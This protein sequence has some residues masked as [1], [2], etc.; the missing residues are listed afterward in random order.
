MALQYQWTKSWCSASWLLQI[1]E[2]E[3]RER[4]LISPQQFTIDSSVLWQ[5]LARLP[6]HPLP[7]TVWACVCP[8]TNCLIRGPNDRAAA[9]CSSSHCRREWVRKQR[10]DS[11]ASAEKTTLLGH[12]CRCRCRHHHHHHHHHLE[13]R[14]KSCNRLERSRGWEDDL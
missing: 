12:W 9:H 6:T 14:E 4:N 13:S 1:E 11:T 10:K 8:V 5:A 2:N 7:L 3:E